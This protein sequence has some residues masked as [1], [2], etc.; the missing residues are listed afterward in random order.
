MGNP[1]NLGCT[2]Y[3]KELTCGVS[4]HPIMQVLINY[5][6]RHCVCGPDTKIETNKFTGEIN[7]D[8]IKI[9]AVLPSTTTSASTCDLH[10]GQQRSCCSKT[11]TANR[12]CDWFFTG[13]CKCYAPPA[14][15]LYWFSSLCGSVHHFPKRDLAQQRRS[16]YLNA[17]ARFA[18]TAAPPPPSDL[19]A[20]LASGLLP[21]PC[22]ASYVS[23]AC[24]D[25]PDGIVHEP[26]QNWLGALLPEGAKVSPPVPKEFLRIHG[27][28]E[29]KLQVV[30]E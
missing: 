10:K 23:F 24:G 19:A 12:D 28:E 11:C 14:G 4:R 25:S 22:N 5:C 9:S 1:H 30:V 2:C 7:Y 26:P 29:G 15:L 17:T 21:S 8:P 6:Y 18:S 13:D 20:Q 16:F 27:G 3:G